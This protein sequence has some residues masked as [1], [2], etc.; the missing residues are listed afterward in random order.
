MGGV[1]LISLSALTYEL[2]LTRIASV[3]MLYHFAFL[4]VSLA[5]LGMSVA[6][7]YIYLLAHRFPKDRAAQ[8]AFLSCLL[9]SLSL[10]LGLVMVL[11]VPPELEL[12]VRSLTTAHGL[13]FVIIVCAMALPFFFSGL[14]ISLILTHFVPYAKDTGISTM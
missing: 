13:G 3:V 6:G 10:P 5:L 12:S 14:S 4:A 9:F 2:V 7:T 11:K 1:F 8:Q